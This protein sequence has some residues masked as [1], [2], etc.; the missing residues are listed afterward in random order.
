MG[1]CLSDEGTTLGGADSLSE[2]PSCIP[3]SPSLSPLPF[4]LW[5]LTDDF[6]PSCKENLSYYLDCPAL[7]AFP[8]ACPLTDSILK[9]L[10]LKPALD[11]SILF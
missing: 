8:T 3:P 5:H 9:P 2:L 6:T 4:A 7:M 11:V 10:G 1:Y